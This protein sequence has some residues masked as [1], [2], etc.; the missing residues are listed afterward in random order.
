MEEEFDDL[1][2]EED[3]NELDIFDEIDDPDQPEAPEL[4]ILD[5]SD[6]EI[7]EDLEE[8]DAEN[9]EEMDEIRDLM[10]KQSSLK[11]AGQSRIKKMPQTIKISIVPKSE[12]RT[13]DILYPNEMA[14]ILAHRAEQIASTGVYYCDQSFNKPERIAYEEMM[15]KRCPLK[16]RRLVGYYKNEIAYYEEFNVNQMILPNV[17]TSK[18]L[19][20]D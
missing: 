1:E 16:I 9:R 7:E 20:F 15:Q 13:S 8:V 17:G 3:Y 2:Y 12:C 6:E 5:E 11:S 14:L 19:G 10:S 4:E 18:D